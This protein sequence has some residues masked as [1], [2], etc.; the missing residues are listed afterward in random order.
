MSSACVNVHTA[1]APNQPDG[2]FQVERIGVENG[3]WGL[4]EFS[5]LQVVH[6]KR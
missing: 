2:R 5:E 3:P 4:A 6:T 1:L